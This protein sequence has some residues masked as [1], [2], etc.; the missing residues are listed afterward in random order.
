MEQNQ[1]AEAWASILVER[2]QKEIEKLDI[3][4]SKSLYNSFEKVVVSEANGDVQKIELAYN[5]YGWF[6]DLGVGKGVKLED[7]LLGSRARK[8]KKWI[9][10]ILNKETYKLA[11]IMAKKYGDEGLNVIVQNIPG[12]I[13][14]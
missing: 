11:E 6:V 13:N 12:K 3:I 10:G 8:P 4:D 14:L 9:A 7:T 1:T 2:W 5:F